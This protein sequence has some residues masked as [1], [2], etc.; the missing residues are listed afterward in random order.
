MDGTTWGGRRSGSSAVQGV[1]AAFHF[2]SAHNGASPL[3]EEVPLGAGTEEARRRW[4]PE[5]SAGFLSRVFFS[6]CNGLVRRGYERP[7]E[8][9]DLWDVAERDEAVRVAA[10]FQAALAATADPVV[11]PQGV[12]WKAML[13][14]HGRTFLG[15]AGIKLIHDIIMF[16]SPYLLELLLHHMGAGGSR[17]GSF[18]LA[19]AILGVAVL[20]NFTVNWYFHKLFRMSLHLKIALIDMIYDKSLRITSAVKADMGAGAIVNLQSNDTAKLWS[21]VLY[22]HVIWNGP[23]QILVV[24]FLLVRIMNWGP[25]MAGLAVTVVVIPL[26]ALLGKAL[27]KSRREQIKYTDQ[28]VKLCAEVITGIKAIKLY[29][30]EVPYVDRIQDLREKEL[31]QIKKTQAL[32]MFNTAMFMSGPVLVGLAAF[33]THTAL[34]YPLTAA[35]A[36][37]ALA[38][39]NLL[40]F[41]I[42]MLPS[43]IMSLVQARVGLQRIQK[44][45]EAEEMSHSAP[46]YTTLPNSAGSTTSLLATAGAAAGGLGGGLGGGGGGSGAPLM[47]REGVFGWDAAG[48]AVLRGVSLEVRRGQLV[49]VVGQVGSGKSSLLAALLGEMHRRS[50]SV[51]VVGSVAYTAQDPWIQNT[52]LR[53][54]VLMGAE[55]DEEAYV[56]TLQA[57]ALV[58]DLELLPAGD[59]SEIGEKGINLS[60]GQKHR[61][62]LARATYTA[63]DIYLL[64]DP[65]SAVDAHVGRHLFDECICGLLGDKTRLLVTHQLQYLPSADLVVVMAGGEVQQVGTYD[66]LVSRGVDFHQFVKEE[67]EET[68]EAGEEEG[69]KDGDGKKAAAAATKEGEAKA[70][71]GQGVDVAEAAA[72]AVPGVDVAGAAAAGGGASAA[73]TSA[74]GTAEDFGG[75]DG[76]GATP[77]AADPLTDKVVVRDG[78][79]GGAG[80][81]VGGV[82][83]LLG[84]DS[85]V[86][87]SLLSPPADPSAASAPCGG[88]AASLSLAAALSPSRP[89]RFGGGALG[90]VGSSM[91]QRGTSGLGAEALYEL[92]RRKLLETMAKKEKDGKLVKVEERAKGRV[93]RSVYA[94]Y[95][96]AWSV[97]YLLP[98]AVVGFALGERG[99]QV[100]QNFVLSAWSNETAEAAE[101]HKTAHNGKYLTLYFILGLVSISIQLLRS[102]LLILGSIRASRLLARRLLDKVVRLPMAF[103]DQ[104]PT[105]RLLNRFTK[106]TEALDIAVSGAVNSA[107]STFV[108]A[109]LSVVV[110]VV[111]TPLAV[112]CFLPLGFVYYRVQQLY[113]ASSRELKR[114]DS[115]AFSP[116][117]QHFGESLAGLTTIRAFRKMD[118]FLDKNRANLNHSN[119]AYWPIQVVNRWL[120]VRLELMGAL[121]VFSAA[122]TVAVIFPR[123]AG[124]A[125]LA[126]TSALNLTGIMN[127]MV[128]QTTE[129]EVNMNSIERMVEYNRYD[130]EAPAVLEGSRP[131]KSWPTEGAISVKELFVRYRPELDPVLRGLSFEVAGREKVGVA[132]RTGCG[133]STLMMTLYRLVEPSSGTIRIDGYDICA[134]GLYDLRSRLSL[135]PQ[136]PVIFSGTVRSNLDPFGQAG[137]DGDMWEALR[138]AGLDETVR[139][140]DK[141]LDAE[142]KEGGANMSVGQRQ[143]L[144]MARALLRRTR[145]LVLDEATSNVDNSTDS[146]IQRTIRTAFKDCTVLTI[147][148]RLH[149]IV[150]SD[151]ILLLE[152]GQM[153][154]YGSPAELL[155]N[156]TSHFRSLVEE[157]MRGGGA[158]ADVVA[159]AFRAANKEGGRAS[160]DGSGAA[161]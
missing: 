60:G 133:K 77:A 82:R 131:P 113:I 111:V 79:A 72:A 70:E 84:A 135:V 5:E 112:V 36:F 57:C 81:D 41:P 148:H 55:F 12:V 42:I 35:V 94:A 120:S 13:R 73:A 100:L 18:G 45:M 158:T 22:M 127:W 104:Q 99:L 76:A 26:T 147:A 96:S 102:F 74:A 25:S 124:L 152:A 64:D 58:A 67:G 24:M 37:P 107:L 142:V 92:E 10:R 106:D 1:K 52:T 153:A 98:V 28:R 160:G 11:H 68:A 34:G 17:G 16:M 3:E 86:F 85:Q 71:A 146:L 91:R 78:A 27:A 14:V 130:E 143:L 121:V 32:S 137:G 157:T 93:D 115:L 59:V 109:L 97:A 83:A 20:E 63:A 128:R 39:F 23:F 105:G 108:T 151:R 49:M 139:L 46:G 140:Y 56:A 123:N 156:P 19:V 21:L 101:E 88:G 2:G 144:C 40:R 136:D 31:A 47:I 119:R 150:D 110:V 75:A 95:L 118:Q 51:R 159:Q 4:A 89:A 6:Y 161:A 138:R 114:L 103:F 154:E 48:E 65:L 149:T 43:Q 125:G 8:H 116:I 62:A 38:L 87:P 29:A 132:G 69:G 53:N 61:V 145:I 117:F 129:L 54:N 80:G 122:V 44:F 66:E 155:R 90:R 15:T 9:D 33:G 126:I 50:G 30:W 134:M 7:L 141:G